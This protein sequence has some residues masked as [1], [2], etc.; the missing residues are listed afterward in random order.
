VDFMGRVKIID[1]ARETGLSRATIDRA[2]NNREGVHPRTRAQIEMAVARLTAGQQPTPVQSPIDFALRL[3]RGM[4]D[5]VNAAAQ[6]IEG[7][8]I[9]IRDLHQQDDAHVLATI[10]ALCQDL[11]RLLV[12]TI[13]NTSQVIMELAKARRRGKIVVALIT[14]LAMEAR[15]A[16]VGIDNRA[17]GET[18]GFLVGRMLGDR[19]TT[20]GI[21]LGDHAYRCHEDR[22]IGFRSALRT[23]FPKVVIAGEA[24]GQ[25]YAPATRAAVRKLLDDHPG[26]GA[27]YNVSGGNAGLARAIEDVGR[28]GDILTVIHEANEV[29]VPLL[30]NRQ[31]DFI[32]SQDPETLLTKAIQQ[33][34]M[35]HRGDSKAQTYL[36]FY[37]H[38]VFNVPS[39]AR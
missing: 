29:S 36:D 34:D 15:D 1:I 10:R 19:P 3:D 32:I 25:D 18:A 16:Y 7:R 37:V 23:H 33:A 30:R 28:T 13:K 21:V 26:I 6:K 4:M 24:L 22:E 14:D 11:S 8:K 5:E 2:M 12:I 17:A 38:T 20:V 39:Y 27:I 35:L 9:V 31:L